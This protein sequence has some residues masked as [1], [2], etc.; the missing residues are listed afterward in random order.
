MCRNTPLVVG[1]GRC[2]VCP[3][4]IYSA[5]KAL[6]HNPHTLVQS[7][8]ATPSRAIQPIKVLPGSCSRQAAA[9]NMVGTSPFL[10]FDGPNYAETLLHTAV[11]D[12][13]MTFQVSSSA[14]G[15]TF[16]AKT[17]ASPRS[18]LILHDKFGSPD[19]DD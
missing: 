16:V 3:K 8:T 7:H 13:T 9:G 4:S 5:R 19:H 12:L 10:L 18:R 14:Q 15:E 2:P 1:S 17:V 6:S 11:S